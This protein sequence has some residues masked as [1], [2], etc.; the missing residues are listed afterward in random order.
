MAEFEAPTY[1]LDLK[2]KSTRSRI[3]SARPGQT[4][5]VRVRSAED[6]SAAPLVA[7]GTRNLGSTEFQVVVE[8]P[9]GEQTH[10][11]GWVE[12]CKDLAALREE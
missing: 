11:R 1:Y 7:K 2:D 5:Q 10:V 12:L 9:A 3:E 6:L 4:V 8:T